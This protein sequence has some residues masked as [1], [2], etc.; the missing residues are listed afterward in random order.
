MRHINMHIYISN[1]YCSH[2]G[3]ME[4]IEKKDKQEETRAATAKKNVKRKKERWRAK[5]GETGGGEEKKVRR[6]KTVREAAGNKTGVLS[7]PDQ[8]QC[9]L[10]GAYKM[11]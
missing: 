7:P 6:R 1:T 10:M 9:F 5:K 4:A 11:Y 2:C 8:E 3:G